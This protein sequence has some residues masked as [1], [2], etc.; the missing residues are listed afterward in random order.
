MASLSILNR[1][2]LYLTTKTAIVEQVKKFRAFGLTA[3]AV[4]ATVNARLEAWRTAKAGTVYVTTLEAVQCQ[5]KEWEA[6]RLVPWGMIAI[7][8]AD[9][10]TAG[11]SKRNKRLI[12]L[13]TPHR[14]M[15]TGTP[16][17]NGLVD[18]YFPVMWLSRNPPWRNWTN[19]CSLEAVYGNPNCPH[20]MTGLRSEER[21]ADYMR[22]LTF[23]MV[24]PDAPKE[25]VAQVVTVPLG[26]RQRAAYEELKKNL[27][28]E[29]RDGT[30]SI[31]NQAVLN[32][33]LR[34]IVSHPEALGIDAPSAKEASLLELL[35]KLEGKTCI[36]TSFASVAKLLGERHGWSVICGEMS[37]NGR[38]DVTD[39]Q[40]DVMIATSAAERGIDLEWLTN[41]ISIDVGFTPATLRQRAGRATRYGR[42]GEAKLFLLQS[43]NTVDVTSEMKI[44][45][46]KLKE[47]RKV[48]QQKAA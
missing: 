31:S 27:L 17:R 21:L 30:L 23:Q 18:T 20:Q 11:A 34:Q 40:P 39:A 5:P 37:A 28:I 6:M 41:I 15:M 48:C 42:T 10:L 33:R 2:A 47:A 36:F 22:P 43:P 44:V 16:L 9:R 25:L 14:L 35:P 8:E 1:P 32:G 45:L 3:E 38:K 26:D 24:N 46:R 19:F 7:D 13:T 4:T 29:A 12:T